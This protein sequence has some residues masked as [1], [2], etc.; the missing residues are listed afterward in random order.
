[1]YDM[2]KRSSEQ[3]G[4]RVQSLIIAT[5]L[6]DADEFSKDDLATLYRTRWHAEINQADCRSSGSLYLGGSAA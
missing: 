6:L 3:P 5:T 4:F 2:E 1:M